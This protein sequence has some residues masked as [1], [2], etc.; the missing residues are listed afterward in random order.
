MDGIKFCVINND[1]DCESD[2]KLVLILK[3]QRNILM[4]A[5]DTNS[6]LLE[7]SDSETEKFALLFKYVDDVQ[8]IRH[9]IYNYSASSTTIKTLTV[10]D[11]SLSTSKRQ[12]R[13]LHQTHSQQQLEQDR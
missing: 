2:L 12:N 3:S 9:D 10:K 11:Q 7:N 13:R 4:K 5:R 8:Y 1:L 6:V